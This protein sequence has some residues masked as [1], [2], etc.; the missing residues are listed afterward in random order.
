MEPES[1][2]SSSA[3]LGIVGSSVKNLL[4]I[5]CSKRLRKEVNTGSSPGRG[6]RA[7]SRSDRHCCVLGIFVYKT[8]IDKILLS[9]IFF[10]FD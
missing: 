10:T 5:V 4:G 9:I 1:R 2:H 3:A 8:K 6:V 7:D